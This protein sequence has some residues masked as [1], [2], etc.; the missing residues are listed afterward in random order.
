[1][2]QLA[3]HAAKS[4]HRAQGVEFDDS[5]RISL[6]D[7]VQISVV[8]LKLPLGCKYSTW[9]I[10][11]TSV[12]KLPHVFMIVFLCEVIFLENDGGCFVTKVAPDGSAAR[13][14][15]VEVGDQLAAINGES[16]FRMKVDDI[17]DMIS[18]SPSKNCIELV[19]LR[20]IGPFRPSRN[21]RMALD[22]PSFDL[23]M[24]SDN[25]LTLPGIETDSFVQPNRQPSK[26]QDKKKG[27]RIFGRGKN[28]AGPKK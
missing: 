1:M 28:K 26:D 27:F 2:T 16:C 18:N 8:E 9:W 24:T 7:D 4:L 5:G 6:H 17:C 13:S 19:F 10:R 14:G 25:I 23:D 11:W 21:S 22:G 15:G 12:R 20:Y 3:L